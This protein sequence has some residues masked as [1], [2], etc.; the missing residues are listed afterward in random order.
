M[1]FGDLSRSR[2]EDAVETLLRYL[3]YDPSQHEGLEETPARVVASLLELTSGT[4]E[5]PAVHLGRTFAADVNV[6]HVIAV[7]R[8]PFAAL[9]EHH[10]LPFTGTATVG[11]KPAEGAR[12]VGLSKLARL[13]D[14][15]AKRLTMQERMTEQITTAIEKNLDTEG[16][17]CVI[18]SAHQCMSLRG[19]QK[20]GASMVTSSMTGVFRSNS[21]MRAEFLDLE[22]GVD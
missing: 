22:R 13:V 10:L 21:A 8:I 12:V 2:A 11:Y 5:D 1:T 9:C 6:D 15:Y 3:G 4:H 7:R 17:A 14:V 18:R 20:V 16:A 19:V